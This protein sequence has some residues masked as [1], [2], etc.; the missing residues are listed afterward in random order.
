MLDIAFIR[1]NPEIIKEGIRKKRMNT[2]IDELLSVD[3][4]VRK[5]RGEV[6]AFRAD[7][8]RI[9]KD[10]PKLKGEE[11]DQALAKVKAAKDGLS[12]FEPELKK[13]EEQFEK[14]MLM[15]PNP[16]LSIVPEGE[17]DDDNVEVRHFGEPTKFDFQPKDH[18]ELAESLD[19]VDMPRAVKF[20]GARMYCLKNEG[21]LLE[22][23]LFKFALELLVSRGFQP[24]IVPQLVRREAMIGTGF[25]PLGEEDTFYVEKDDLYLIGTS[26][27]PLVSYHMDEILNEKDLPK[28]YCGY[29]SC[30][31]REAGSYG[32]DT[33]GFYRLHQFNKVEQVIICV[34]D[35]EVSMV[36]HRLLLSNSEALMQALGLPH[37]VALACGAEIGQGQVLKHE[38]ET[39]MPSRNRYSETHSCSSL[40]EFQSR[41]LRI[42]WRG[43]NSKVNYCHT[44]NNT[45]V[46]SPRILI[47]LLE[48]FQN[49]DGSVTIPEVLRPY[50]T[51][52]ERIEPK[53]K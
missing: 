43:K 7:R 14:L 2:D 1:S 16:P 41:R 24:M 40:H 10:I 51:G 32:R 45:A 21:A 26:E 49:E 15:V 35:P 50:M 28:H 53:S 3:E 8:N 12:R 19:I 17:S 11:K 48:N 9:S 39:W 23:A 46:A 6:E 33:R 4:E 38:I 37:R 13:L 47:P 36:E 44:L 52:M 20:A 25:F 22:F 29:S 42:R 31:R 18:L 27:V 5:V 30:F 34:N